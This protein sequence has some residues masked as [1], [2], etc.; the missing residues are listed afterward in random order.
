MNNSERKAFWDTL[1]NIRDNTP[2]KIRSLCS[3][4]EIPDSLCRFRSVSENSLMQLQENKLYYSSADYYDDPF[5]TFI[6]VDLPRLKDIHSTFSKMLEFDKSESLN[7]LNKLGSTIGISGE[8]FM[9]NLKENPLDI[10]RFEVEIISIREAIQKNLFSICFC[11]NELNETLWIKYANNYKGFVLVYDMKSQY[12]FLCGQEQICKNCRS[13]REMPS[14]Y[15]VYYSENAYD[16]TKFALT[17]MLRREAGK[18]PP[19][20][21]EM[22]NKEVVWDE[23]RISLIKKKCHEYDEEWRMLRPTM[24]LERT[25]I[26]MKPSK[27]ILGLRMPEYEKLLTVSAA[28]VAGISRVEELFINEKD[29]LDSKAIELK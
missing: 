1:C 20:I 24:S 29:Q 17:C 18:I 3:T 14:L 27:I 21:I 26:K 12:T 4:I 22:F 6:H 5:D 2:E 19:R 7:I 23:E 16:A 13:M 28:K 8:E 25:C 11:E 15:P 10:P 9:N